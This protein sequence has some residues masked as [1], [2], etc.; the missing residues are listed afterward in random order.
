MAAT[1]QEG[2]QKTNEQDKLQ[3][4]V[5]KNME[6]V[7]AFTKGRQETKHEELKKM[8]ENSYAEAVCAQLRLPNV[9]RARSAFYHLL[10]RQSKTDDLTV[11]QFFSSLYG[12]DHNPFKFIAADRAPVEQIIKSMLARVVDNNQNRARLEDLLKHACLEEI[13]AFTDLNNPT[14]REAF[15]CLLRRTDLPDITVLIIWNE[16]RILFGQ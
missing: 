9:Q 11:L 12:Q 5:K 2:V 10:R 3:E 16:F 8:L 4:G 13:C 1:S 6:V 15:Y 7:M 14:F